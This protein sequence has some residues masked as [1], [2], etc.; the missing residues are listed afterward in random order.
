MFRREKN[1]KKSSSENGVHCKSVEII[2][3]HQQC[4]DSNSV[5]SCKDGKKKNCMRRYPDFWRAVCLAFTEEE[6]DQT[7]DRA[8]TV[9]FQCYAKLILLRMRQPE[10]E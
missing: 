6:S 5:E 4:G 8:P 1:K 7:F 2:A 3:V 10:V 9:S